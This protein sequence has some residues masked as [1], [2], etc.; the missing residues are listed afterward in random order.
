MRLHDRH[1]SHSSKFRQEIALE[2][3]GASRFGFAALEVERRLCG[4]TQPSA[5]ATTEASPGWYGGTCLLDS[6]QINTLNNPKIP[7]RPFRR[8]FDKTY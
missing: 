2:Q 4:A 1:I 8:I 3:P 7:R 5:A 6:L